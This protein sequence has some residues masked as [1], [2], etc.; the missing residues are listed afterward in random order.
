M[1]TSTPTYQ[2]GVFDLHYLIGEGGMGEVWLGTHRQLGT[3]VAIKVL[4]EDRIQ[5][6]R[7][8]ENFMR[9][10]ESVARLLHPGIIRVFDYGEIPASLAEKSQGKWAATAPYLTMELA[11][12][13]SLA[14][15]RGVLTWRQLR[16][17][18]IEILSA[19]AHAHAR[20][21]IHRDLKPE[22]ILLDANAANQTRVKLTDFGIV[23]QAEPDRPLDTQNMSALYAGT[24]AYMS[25]EQIRGRWRDFGPW[26]DL[27]AVGCIAYELCHGALP[28]DGNNL[29]DIAHQQL[30]QSI[31]PLVPRMPVPRGFEDFILKLM[32]K[33]PTARYQ[34]AIDAAWALEQLPE[35]AL[36]DSSPE[37]IALI[38]TSSHLD[39]NERTSTLITLESSP[40]HISRDTLNTDLLESISPFQK[41]LLYQET[42]S[43]RAARPYALPPLPSSWHER[44]RDADI[45]LGICGA[46]L[47][48]HGLREVPLVGRTSE[49][50]D[51][52]HRMLHSYHTS[53]PTA[54]QLDGP[55]GIGKTR[56]ATWLGARAHELGAAHIL[57]AS[58]AL[59]SSPRQGL[60]R[61]FSRF[62]RTSNLSH[63][64]V[65]RRI[66][67]WLEQRS[68]LARSSE[69]IEQDARHITELLSPRQESAELADDSPS[70]LTRGEGTE[71]TRD[72][73]LN[74]PR[75]RYTV[76]ATLLEHLCSSRSL[77]IIADDAHRSLETLEIFK[78]ILTEPAT[79]D[80]PIFIL[81]TTAQ[82]HV[83]EI[84]PASRRMMQEIEALPFSSHITLGHLDTDSQRTLIDAILPLEDPLPSEIITL[85]HGHPMFALQ[86]IGQWIERD[87]LEVGPHGYRL[88]TGSEAFLSQT[89][90]EIWIRR[91]ANLLHRIEHL[92]P[93]FS[94]EDIRAALEIAAAL[95]KEVSFKEWG[96][97]C[98]L[99]GQSIPS[100]LVREMTAQGFA[101]IEQ[102]HWAFCHDMLRM[103]LLLDAD[104]DGRLE[105]IN[106]SCARMID[107]LYSRDQ[108]G[109][110]ERLVEH[111]LK[112][113]TP[114]LA[115]TPL[116]YLAQSA[117]QTN[118][119]DLCERHLK[120][121]K[122]LLPTDRPSQARTR[123][124]F[125]KLRW[126][127]AR[128]GV[129][130]AQIWHDLLAHDR[131]VTDAP[132][133]ELISLELDA[134]QARIPTH[135]L[136][137][138]SKLAEA[139]AEHGN[140]QATLHGTLLRA[141]LEL[142]R[143]NV[144][145]CRQHARLA[146]E[147]GKGLDDTSQLDQL[148]ANT[149]FLLGSAYRIEGQHDKATRALKR[150]EASFKK[151]GDRHGLAMVLLELGHMARTQRNH[152]AAHKFYSD[153]R[154]QLAEID[155]IQEALAITALAMT[156]LD[157]DDLDENLALCQDAIERLVPTKLHLP[158][159]I[160]HLTCAAIHASRGDIRSWFLSHQEA[161]N[162]LETQDIA[163]LEVAQ[164]AEHAAFALHERRPQDAI[165]A[166]MLASTHSIRC[167]R[168]SAALEELHPSSPL[169]KS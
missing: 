93:R 166:I 110:P 161:L 15:L 42:S 129:P 90:D 9:E 39:A 27:Y 98:S 68:W 4:R 59:Q 24:P 60:V 159:A 13:G 91:I 130:R 137:L 19:L 7:M 89:L 80:L 58:H 28:F 156:H 82:S 97:T 164:L 86:L 158:L 124:I 47:G 117:L 103:Q 17:L 31:P 56:L 128:F 69:Q 145:P 72:L 149:F 2:L 127:I 66:L 65:H 21:L 140:T 163:S 107:Q 44:N 150:S 116:L 57:R 138:S 151:S 46:G 109:A 43:T 115:I 167:G 3:S 104:N 122:A 61:M 112:S 55:Q 133:L 125:L 121:L 136:L 154:Q 139:C 53:S 157:A 132:E 165:H 108:Q 12:R 146:L 40:E 29:F 94:Q 152:A 135:H 88:K 8:R 64:K 16:W 100:S 62:L 30:S 147:L 10:A 155:H 67:D 83:E 160:A 87:L 148:E 131:L 51:I 119:Y 22:N 26:T 105:A 52:W 99:H 120:E 23:H 11:N 85:S 95:G 123:Y 168:S 54:I 35:I 70:L 74:T 79:K 84:R 144:K 49:R 50:D 41:D 134:L 114:E 1:S 76:I 169:T 153:A 96:M 142:W 20:D 102:N 77:F 81:F 5:D 141:R 32:E 106:M 33:E 34:R 37:P 143:A 63:D 38:H 18:L 73:A 101:I 48:L 162:L 78:L 118:D 6:P 14:Q 126:L 113:T 71:S 36:A 25:P 75:E 45:T 92:S 111:L